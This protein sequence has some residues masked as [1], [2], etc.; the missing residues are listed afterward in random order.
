MLDTKRIMLPFTRNDAPNEIGFVLVSQIFNHSK[1][2]PPQ[3]M[4]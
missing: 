2:G 1:L 4:V 3:A